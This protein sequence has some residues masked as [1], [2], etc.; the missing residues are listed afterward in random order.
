MLKP[1][2]PLIKQHSFFSEPSKDLLWLGIATPSSHSR[3]SANPRCG[4]TA[5][6]SKE[7]TPMCGSTPPPAS[8]YSNLG[9]PY[10]IVQERSNSS[11]SPASSEVPIPPSKRPHFGLSC[12]REQGRFNCN[13]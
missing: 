1:S 11:R 5:C 9:T 12:Y 4:K 6:P 3:A 8:S 2:P 7:T 13:L 10:C